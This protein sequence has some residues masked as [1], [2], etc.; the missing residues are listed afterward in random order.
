L[1]RQSSRSNVVSNKQ[2]YFCFNP[3]PEIISG[4]PSKF[5]K[6][7]NKVVEV[8][9]KKYKVTYELHGI[10]QDGHANYHGQNLSSI[11]M[12]RFTKYVVKCAFKLKVEKKIW[13]KNQ[14]FM[15]TCRKNESHCH[16]H[17]KLQ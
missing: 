14:L 10:F 7:P 6:F 8:K 4:E 3:Q 12:A 5:A 17:E 11:K 2:L 13:F 1:Y 15:E 16:W 9:F